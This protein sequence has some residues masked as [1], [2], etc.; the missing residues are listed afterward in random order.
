MSERERIEPDDEEIER[1]A[2]RE[3]GQPRSS[4]EAVPPGTVE[5]HERE[6]ESGYG[7]KRDEPRTSADQR[8]NEEESEP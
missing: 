3:S 7:G 6:H 5:N 1:G 8:M 4:A 2:T